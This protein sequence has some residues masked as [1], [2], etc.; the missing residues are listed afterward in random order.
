MSLSSFHHNLLICFYYSVNWAVGTVEL[1]TGELGTVE[2]GTGE[3]PYSGKFSREKI[4]ANFT[5]YRLFAKILS[6]KYSIF[7]PIKNFPLYGRH[8]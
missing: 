4:F 7:S 5:T 3:L 1:G 8:W 6:E 2:L